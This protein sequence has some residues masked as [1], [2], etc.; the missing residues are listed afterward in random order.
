M[1]RPPRAH[2]SGL[3][4]HVLNRGAGRAD[5]FR[6]ARDAR[7][8][9]RLLSEGSQGSCVEVH[10][11]CLM[12]NHYHLLLRDPEG[13]L[14]AFMHRLGS[15][16]TR[17]FNHQLGSDGP[18]FRG[19]FNSLHVDTPEYQICSARYIHRNPLDIRPGEPLTVYPWSSYAS[20]VGVR[21]APAWLHTEVLIELHGGSAAMREFV[22]GTAG[23]SQTPIDWAI[24][25][26]IAETEHD[27]LV[28][29]PHVRRTI[30]IA[31]FE[32]SDGRLREAL[33]QRLA[34]P[35]TGAQRMALTRARQRLAAS[36]ELIDVV[37]R[38][39]RLVK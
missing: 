31:L 29:A 14:S 18:L 33:D 17:Y 32:R 22:E 8:F 7:H 9:L 30:E 12:G 25:M 21:A 23:M 15:M 6:S 35:S 13:E 2:R 4:N 37:D 27:R 19:R 38:A 10:A 39:F 26:A 16:Y 11:Y 34:F 24:D 5:I 28:A 3:W 36:P 1:A 20:H